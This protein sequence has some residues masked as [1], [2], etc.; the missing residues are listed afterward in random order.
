MVRLHV[1]PHIGDVVLRKLQPDQLE[2]LY[3]L[4]LEEGEH[5]G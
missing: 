4:L 1:I 2:Q 3:S 5:G